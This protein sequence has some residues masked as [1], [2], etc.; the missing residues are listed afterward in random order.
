MTE[1][2]QRRGVKTPD[3]YEPDVLQGANIA[4][5]ITAMPAGTGNLPYVYGTDDA[6]LAAE[7]LGKHNLDTLLVLDNKE[8]KQPVGVIT[9]KAILKYYSEQKLKD[10]SYDSPKR[11]QKI[12]VHGRKLMKKMGKQK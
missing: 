7:M 6:G 12:M 10:H 11:T 3:A 4:E 8:S 2:I 5:L 1:K 9:T